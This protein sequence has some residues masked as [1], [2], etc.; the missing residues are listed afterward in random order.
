MK[1]AK[2]SHHSVL[3][4][5][6]NQYLKITSMVCK[7]RDRETAL[8]ISPM[9]IFF[10]HIVMHTKIIKNLVIMLPVKLLSGI[11]KNVFQ[12]CNLIRSK[13]K[14]LI[15]QLTQKVRIIFNLIHSSRCLKMVKYLKSG[16]RNLLITQTT[17]LRPSLM[18]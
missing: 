11:M 17:L 3:S 10:S 14:S 15:I 9:K 8:P 2:F 12:K 7:N 6:K 13:D 4:M 18:K 5:K 1:T 16:T